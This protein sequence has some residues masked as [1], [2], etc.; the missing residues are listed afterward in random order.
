MIQKSEAGKTKKYIENN[1]QTI[2]FIIGPTAVGKSEVAVE[3][4]QKIDAEI[5]SCDSM[6]IY[7]GMKI[8]SCQP[9][10]PLRKKVPHHLIGFVSPSLNYDVS[11]Y[12]KKAMRKIKE[13]L[14]KG[15]TPLFVGGTGLY[16]SALVDGIFE[17][18]TKNP[19][20]RA[21]LLNEVKKYGNML[22]YQRLEKID[23]VACQKI[24]PNDTKR[25]VRALEVFEATGIPISQLQRK[26]K[27]LSAEFEVKIF[28]LLRP[29]NQL[30]ARINQRVEK[31][32]DEGLVSEVK[33][34][35]QKT[36]GLT[37]QYAIG[38]RELSGYFS[39]LYSLDKAKELVK[40]N[41]RRYAKRQLCWFRKDKRIL[42]ID[43]NDND[44]PKK[45]ANIIFKKFLSQSN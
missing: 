26:R 9:S 13:V 14:K 8:L 2:I 31:M 11:Q 42:W 34:L 28:G 19:Q 41:T 7:R 18:E 38:I 24:H 20:I 32:F 10:P 21:R 3:L 36:L 4:A 16:V 44:T 39:H 40:R 15:K 12:R 25:I 35:L 23:P 22:L 37:A 6:Q 45:I 5:L 33:K 1:R 29:R 30:Y 17:Q 27:G 43:V